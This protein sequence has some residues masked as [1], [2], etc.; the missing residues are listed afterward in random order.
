MV[1]SSLIYN[2]A[3]SVMAVFINNSPEQCAK[4]CALLE[5]GLFTKQQMLFSLYLDFKDLLM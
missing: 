4:Q 1:A 3:C 5:Y 2:V